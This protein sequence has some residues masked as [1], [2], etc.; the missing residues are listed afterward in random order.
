MNIIGER[1][2][3]LASRDPTKVGRTGLVRLETA[4]TLLIDSGNRNIR[5]EK[6]GSAFKV[7]STGAVITG[8]DIVGRL[9]DRLGRRGP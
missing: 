9:Q 6:E 2:I 1:L 3:I 4:K 8:F 5:V 7:I